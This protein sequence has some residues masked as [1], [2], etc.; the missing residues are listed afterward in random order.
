[1][2]PAEL[3][4]EYL[5]SGGSFNPELMEHDKVRDI[6]IAARDELD[7]LT[8]ENERLREEVEY[9][10]ADLD[11]SRMEHPEPSVEEAPKSH[12]EYC[13]RCD[14]CGWYE[15]GP[16]MQTKCEVCNGTGVVRKPGR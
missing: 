14:G 1:M 2:T 5:S 16:Q 15:G 7:R 3:I 9:L 12:L 6:V 11:E 10:F 13:E 4:T 8:A